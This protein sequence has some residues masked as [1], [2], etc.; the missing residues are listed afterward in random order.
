MEF[1]SS[2]FDRNDPENFKLWRSMTPEEIDQDQILHRETF[3]KRSKKDVELTQRTFFLTHKFLFYKKN[4]SDTKIRGVMELEWVRVEYFTPQDREQANDLIEDENDPTSE[5]YSIKFIKNLKFTEIF[6]D[7][8]QIFEFWKHLL[9]AITIQT[10][11]HTKY[12]VLKMLGKGS[13]AR[14]R[15]TLAFFFNFLGLFGRKTER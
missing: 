1:I 4:E 7:N 12:K 2:F 11:F 10:D 13:F 14:V 3:F 15:F 9:S 8:Q 6:T 5:L